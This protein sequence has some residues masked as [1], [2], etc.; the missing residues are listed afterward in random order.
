MKLYKVTSK[1]TLAIE[2]RTYSA[3]DK[4][5]DL[6]LT[7]TVASSG[8]VQLT[9]PVVV[10]T[11]DVEK[12]SDKVFHA[13]INTQKGTKKAHIKHNPFGIRKDVFSSNCYDCLTILD[14]CGAL[15]NA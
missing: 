11:K 10:T 15:H 6:I 1:N 13:S 9:K 3:V 12:V 14:Y 2:G 5:S 4:G 7:H 8:L